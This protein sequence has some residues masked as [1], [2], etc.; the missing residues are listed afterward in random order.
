MNEHQRV[1]LGS[2]LHDIGKFYMRTGLPAEGYGRDEWREEHG[3]AGAHARWSASFFSQYVPGQW[4]EAGW[5]ALTHH[6]PQE[7]LATLVQEADRL[8]ARFDR[9][10]RPANELGDIARDRLEALCEQVVLPRRGRNGR[11]PGRR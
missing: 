9:T 8:A 2:L 5:Q 11:E 3:P 7:P 1:I 6:A 10:K 4:R